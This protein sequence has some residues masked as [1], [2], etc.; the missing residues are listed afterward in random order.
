MLSSLIVL[1]ALT[2]QTAAAPGLSQAVLKGAY[3]QVTPAMCLVRYSSEITN[4]A[5]GQVSRRDSSAVGLL[6]SADGLVMAHGH[7]VL[8]N[9]RPFSI[10]VTVGW[11][12]DEKE[13][14]AVLLR[15]PDDINVVFLRIE[16]ADHPPFPYVRFARETA[17]DV[18][19]PVALFGVLPEA[20]DNVRALRVAYVG[21]ILQKPRTTYCLDAP[22]SF[23]YV[24]GPVINSRGRVVGVLGFDLSPGE[25]GELHTRSGYPLIYQAALFRKYIANPPGDKAVDDKTPDAWLGVY[26]QP[27]TE[28]LAAYWGLR[29]EGGLVVSTVVAGSPARAAGLLSG[30]VITAFDGTPI[31][32]RVDRDVMAFTKLVRDTGP[33]KQVN[34]RVL[35]NG[36]PKTI[37]V[38]LGIRPP[39]SR[40][41]GEYE[42]KVL[43][44][45]A[46]E[47]TTDVRIALNLPEDVKGVIVRR[48]KSGGSAQLARIRPGV[49]ILSVG[50]YGIESLDDLKAAVAKLAET[51]P[52]E[53]SIFARFGPG[54]GFFRLE[55]RWNDK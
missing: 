7:M 15:K 13:Y 17:L 32:A 11:G 47:I 9:A 39:S 16:G 4:P 35:R 50:D 42:D 40:D 18:G 49:I 21:A 23:G 8:D 2:T 51:K 38:E 12:E 45:T 48:V 25:G 20:L 28:D 54:T 1:A 27:L 53:V 29:D 37:T 43:G 5:S 24:G 44:L 3:E 34:I 52:K 55:P 6:V 22:V 19:S 31:K 41:A 36:E 46:R 26:T 14:D 10:T 33:G 30:D